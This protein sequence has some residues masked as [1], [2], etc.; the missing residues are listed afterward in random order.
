MP[1]TQQ[2]N[3]Q[4]KGICTSTLSLLTSGFCHL[5]I[6]GMGFGPQINMLLGRVE[7]KEEHM[8]NPTELACKPIHSWLL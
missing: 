3:E 7:D 4:H 8:H 2:L 1:V 5:H 6:I